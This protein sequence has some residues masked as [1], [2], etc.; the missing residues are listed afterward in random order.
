MARR[1]TLRL[2]YN[3]NL[4]GRA[5]AGRHNFTNLLR[6]AFQAQGF[7]VAI[8]PDTG[9]ERARTRI[10][11][12]YS[13]TDASKPLPGRSLSMR[14]AYVGAFW[15]LEQTHERWEF[16]VARQDFDPE[17]IDPDAAD[18]F[19]TRWQTILFS[20]APARARYGGYIY[21]PLQARLLDQR[22]FQT[23]APMQML[24]AICRHAGPRP[25]VAT[26]HPGVDYSKAERAGVETLVDRHENL[27]LSDSPKADLLRSCDVVACQNSAVALNGYFFRK[28]AILFAKIDFHHIA[29]NVDE[30]GVAEA[31]HRAVDHRPDFARYLYWFLR[32]N[33]IGAGRPDA[34]DQIIRLVRARGWDV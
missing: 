18:R 26:L 19:M 28:P 34:E 5:R 22:S 33:A 6:R 12:A 20:D 30:L 2:L 24:E 29:L 4:L 1:K 27:S 3:S 9:F 14:R 17:A 11:G 13:I 31:L 10:S 23:M 8:A 16:E 25:V 32:L 15:R 7:D 21:V